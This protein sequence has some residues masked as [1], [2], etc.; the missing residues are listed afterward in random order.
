[1]V[2][3]EGPDMSNKIFICDSTLLACT[4]NRGFS[5]ANRDKIKIAKLLNDLGIHQMMLDISSD[6]DTKKLL[7][8][9]KPHTSISF[10]GRTRTNTADIEAALKCG[11]DAVCISVFPVCSVQSDLLETQIAAAVSYAKKEGLYAA[12]SLENASAIH[13]PFMTR[14]AKA[15]VE[16]GADRIRYCDSNG[17][18]NPFT[19]FS[20]VKNLLAQVPCSLEI[21]TNNQLGLATANVLAGIKAGANWINT[22]VNG[23]GANTKTAIMEQVIM[24]LQHLWHMDLNIQTKLFKRT[25]DYVAMV[26]GIDLPSWQ[27]IVGSHV[28]RHESGI[29]ADGVL[30]NPLIYEPFPPECVGLDRSILIG[31]HSGSRALAS[32]LAEFGIHLNH[33]EIKDLLICVQEAAVKIKHNLSDEELLF[34]YR[35]WRT[36]KNKNLDFP[37]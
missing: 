9:I 25:A 1:A 34:I 8:N 22:S 35:D 15:A 3:K 30:K 18:M 29:H 26:C 21:Q 37:E 28:F 7:C 6:D 4:R 14:L 2:R 10:M 11:V 16:A 17:T 12:V 20:Q 32:K 13:P 33:Q 27:P 36:G 31:K 24:V 23:L 19:L 5:A